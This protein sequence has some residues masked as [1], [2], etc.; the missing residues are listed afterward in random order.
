MNGNVMY[1]SYLHTWLKA[2]SATG[3]FGKKYLPTCLLSWPA[4][5][6]LSKQMEDQG[7]SPPLYTNTGTPK[8]TGEGKSSCYSTVRIS[9][10][11]HCLF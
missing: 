1:T 10:N 2:Y 8:Q 6:A 7:S 4:K 9:L 5:A 11:S 3:N